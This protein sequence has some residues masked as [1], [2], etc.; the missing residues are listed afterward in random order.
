MCHA[1]KGDS[2]L[3]IVCGSIICLLRSQL[4]PP[5]Q[6]SPFNLYFQCLTDLFNSFTL[7]NLS[8]SLLVPHE[9]GPLILKQPTIKKSIPS[10]C[11]LQAPWQHLFK[12]DWEA[13]PYKSAQLRYLWPTWGKIYTD[14]IQESVYQALAEGQ[15]VTG[16]GE[17]KV[18]RGRVADGG[19]DERRV[20]VIKDEKRKMRGE[21]YSHYSSSPGVL[22]GMRCQVRCEVPWRYSMQRDGWGKGCR[23]VKRQCQVVTESNELS[24][25]VLYS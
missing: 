5:L 8:L 4:P 13:S 14:W 23:R 18:D 24:L 19:E 2:V 16:G 10:T 7:N 25:A 3:D 20:F 11:S 9:G 22:S 12:T 21:H 15:R 17:L 1:N 6:P